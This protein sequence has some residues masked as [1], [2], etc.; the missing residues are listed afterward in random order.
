MVWVKNAPGKTNQD[1]ADDA[2]LV[3]VVRSWFWGI[4]VVLRGMAQDAHLKCFLSDLTQVLFMPLGC[5][6][7]LHNT[8]T[9]CYFARM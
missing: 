4:I 7:L 9:T 6:I 3:S 1:I 2:Q 8:E 5:F